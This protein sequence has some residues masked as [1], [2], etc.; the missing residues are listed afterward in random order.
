MDIRTIIE[1]KIEQ[2]GLTKKEVAERMGIIP[3][4]INAMIASPSWPT[5][6]KLYQAL[7]ISPS[8]LVSDPDAPRLYT[9]TPETGLFVCPKCGTQLKVT[10][11]DEE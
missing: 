2:A 10:S 1:R 7:G 11:V 4:N 9:I 5:I 3:N 8:E 6:E